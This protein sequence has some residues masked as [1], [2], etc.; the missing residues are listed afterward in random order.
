[1]KIQF[2][3][4]SNNDPQNIFVRMWQSKDFDYST[5]TGLIVFKNDFSNTY[6]KIKNKVGIP[7][8]DKIN[9][10]L[11]ALRTHLHTAYN[12]TVMKDSHFPA[13]WL[14][15]NVNTFFNRVTSTEPHKKFLS[16]FALHY[17]Q[18][19]AT[20]KATGLPLAKGTLKK[21]TTCHNCILSFEKH[22]GKRIL[23]KAVDY[24]FY[25]DFV[26]FCRTEKGYTDNTTG[27]N[28]K[29][30]KMWL[31]EAN[32]R[33]L[34]NVDTSD[35]RAM[36]NETKD[37]YLTETEINK[38]FKTN[39][40]HNLRLANTRDILII[41]VRTG[42][43]VSDFMKLKIDNING[44]DIEV[45]TQKTGKPVAIPMHPQIRTIIERN[46]GTLPKPLSDQKFNLYLKE[47]CEMAGIT[48]A[49]DGARQNP[50]TKRK[51]HGTYPKF[52][53]ITSHTCRRS[54]ASNLYGK[55]SNATIM[56][57]TGHSTEREFLK[58]IKITPKQHAETLREYWATLPTSE[59]E[60]APMRKVK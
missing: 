9:N 11:E 34:C 3:V 27:I 35:F 41:G 36:T 57:I 53:L 37:V 58:Y 30:L 14:K 29:A 51:E 19:E 5:K 49:V 7:N 32:K 24:D 59:G 50:K 48:K 17:N 13:N 22:R 6:Q 31:N 21:Y 10:S 42:L 12:D 56:G 28:I 39:F 16:D 44:N 18:T 2:F 45:V 20:S 1:M 43:R 15:D 8:K 38:I 52:E 60:K 40:N 54:F 47:V 4:R 33:G 26:A 25:K 46:G 55:I 23:L